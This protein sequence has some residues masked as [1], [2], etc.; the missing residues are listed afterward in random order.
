MFS[1]YGISNKYSLVVQKKNKKRKEK[2]NTCMRV[3][4]L[5]VSYKLQVRA[6]L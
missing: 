1:I 4:V 5:F 6:Q 3:R 2:K